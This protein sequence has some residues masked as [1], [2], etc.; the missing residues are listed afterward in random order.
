MGMEDGS[1]TAPLTPQKGW[2]CSF[3]LKQHPR[4]PGCAAPLQSA[5]VHIAYDTGWCAPCV[6][7]IHLP[8]AKV[9][10]LVNDWRLAD[11]WVI[12]RGI[13]WYILP[14]EEEIP[15]DALWKRIATTSRGY[16]FLGLGKDGRIT[17]ARPPASEYC[18]FCH[19]VPVV[20]TTGQLQCP[21]CANLIA[22]YGPGTYRV[23]PYSPSGAVPLSENPR[24][25]HLLPQNQSRK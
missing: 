24:F 23:L 8:Y 13:Q 19:Y 2:S 1:R 3:N 15:I 20:T 14:Y 22:E 9:R 6:R 10:P 12:T 7:N 17:K 11:Y 4:C 18:D 21:A 5:A 25:A 16:S